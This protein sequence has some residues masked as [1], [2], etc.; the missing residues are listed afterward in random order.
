MQPATLSVSDQTQTIAVLYVDLAGRVTLN[1]GNPVI[2]CYYNLNVSDTLGLF[3]R[4]IKI[5]VNTQTLTLRASEA[6]YTTGLTIGQ[7]DTI[8][9]SISNNTGVN[10]YQT[11]SLGGVG[12]SFISAALIYY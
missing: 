7:T 10:G 4:T 11:F 9:F 12:S 6:L 8:T 2:P 3:T 1:G 5:P